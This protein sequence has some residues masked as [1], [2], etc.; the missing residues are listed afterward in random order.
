M[1]VAEM[2]VG[3]IYCQKSVPLKLL[4][5]ST[6]DCGKNCSDENV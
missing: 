4:T 1:K 2:E 3:M 5:A 6:D